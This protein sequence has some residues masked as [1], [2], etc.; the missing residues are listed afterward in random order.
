MT[1]CIGALCAKAYVPAKDM[2]VISDRVLISAGRLSEKACNCSLGF[3]NA[4]SS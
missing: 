3:D 1:V 2:I 4:G